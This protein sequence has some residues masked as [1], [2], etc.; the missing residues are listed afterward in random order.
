MLCRVYSTDIGKK[1]NNNASNISKGWV[2][3]KTTLGVTV[4]WSLN[5]WLSY[6]RSIKWSLLSHT[7]RYIIKIVPLG[8][9]SN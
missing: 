3:S 8:N 7:F 9:Q 5:I 1:R 4:L 2:N 6:I